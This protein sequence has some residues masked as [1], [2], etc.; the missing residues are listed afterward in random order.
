MLLAALPAFAAGAT[1]TVGRAAA[2]AGESVSLAVTLTGGDGV[3]NFD[4]AVSVPAGLTLT[5][6]D[7]EGAICDGGM[8][9]NPEKGL[10]CFALATDAAQR[11]G[12]LFTLRFAVAADA[13]AGSYP[14]SLRVREGGAFSNDAGPITAAFVAGGVEI[15]G[16]GVSGGGSSGGTITI[17]DPEITPLPPEPVRFSDVAEGAWY[18]DCV[19]ALAAQGVVSGYPDGTFRPNAAVSAGEALKLI[20]L[21]A[22]C[23]LAP[24]ESGHW[25][26]PFRAC[27]AER[28]WLT[29]TPEQLDEPITR[30]RIAELF[31]KAGGIAPSESAERFPDTD[32]PYAAALGESGL[33]IGYADGSFGPERPMT[34]AELCML[35]WRQGGAAE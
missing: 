30:V 7:T 26:E 6:V 34:R 1:V 21:A 24:A 8:V 9:A 28:G 14:V 15:A 19:T 5:A 29:V 13:A 11:E 3:R 12:T 25:A 23:G 32:S 33:L 2:R 22:G 35:L 16:Q 4:F 17:D 20:L 10:L 31:A 27:A 18:Y